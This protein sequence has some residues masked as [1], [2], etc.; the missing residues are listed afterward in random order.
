MKVNAGVR[1]PIAEDR[2]GELY[3]IPLNPQILA[4]KLASKT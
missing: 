4:K 1:V 2:V 3:S